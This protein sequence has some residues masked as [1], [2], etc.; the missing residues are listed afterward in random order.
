G[1]QSWGVLALD[2]HDIGCDSFAASAHKWFMGPKEVGILYVRAGL[3][4]QIWPNTIG[5]TGEIKVELEL[6]NALKFET[7]GRRD[8]AA[9]AAL[10][11][12]ADLHALIGPARIQA[13]VVELAGLLKNGLKEAGGTVG[14][15]AEPATSRGGGR[16]RE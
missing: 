7:L 14:A 2:V 8:A 4:P 3:A 15:P 11:E 10:G 16:R 6:E 1:A 12:T 5:Y 13:R 9:I